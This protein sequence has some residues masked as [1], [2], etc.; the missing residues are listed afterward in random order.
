MKCYI[1][2]SKAGDVLSILPILYHDFKETG[3]R[4][5]LVISPEYAS[6]LEGVSYVEPVI[7]NGDSSDLAGAILFAKKRFSQVI[8]LQ[9]HG[10]MPVQQLTPSF[11]LDQWRRAGAVEHFEDWPL[12][13]D[14]RNADREK[15]LGIHTKAKPYILFGDHSQSSPFLPKEELARLIQ[16]EF[17]HH[18]FVRLS[19]VK[20]HRIYDLLGLYDRA[21]C[22]VTIE[23][24]HVHLS[25]ASPVP[26][27]VLAADGWRGSAP[28]KKFALY[29]KYADYERMK[30]EIIQAVKRAINPPTVIDPPKAAVSVSCVIPIYK[31]TADM[32]NKCL[33]A[34]LPQ[35]DEI[36]VTREAAAVLPEGVI[37][38]TKIRHVVSSESGIGF[39]RNV[40]FGAKHATG[41]YL[42]VLNDDVYLAPDAVDK[43]KAVMAHDV[44]CVGHFLSFPN[45]RIYHSGKTR[46]PDG[47]AGFI[48]IDGIGTQ[49]TETVCYPCEMENVNGASFM[50]RRSV[51][52]QIGGYD[53]GYKF[54][55]EDDDICMKVRQAGFKIWYTPFARGVHLSQ[56]E[57]SKVPGINGIMATSNARFATKW[58]LYFV[59]NAGNTLGN[60]D[61]LK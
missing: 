61:Y 5:K 19:Q 27:I 7:W 33:L 59:H 29:I 55:C 40:N 2:L 54:Y 43:M 26:T 32:L 20:A 49:T 50:F 6:V 56:S 1:Q 18:E 39:G 52:E 14:K 47:S 31:P 9:T 60:F 38:N 48:H 41:D 17:P 30:V 13:F 22:L 8:A 45:G 34:V 28:H 24:A 23:T 51:F 21:A 25:K 37:G 3:Q 42:L 46:N 44:G 58:M 36:I 57:T 10:N 53:E 11:Q 35:V 12:V 4:P 16:A 15:D